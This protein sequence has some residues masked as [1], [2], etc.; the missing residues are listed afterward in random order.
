MPTV[1][2]LLRTGRKED[3]WQKCCG[4]LD[5][6]IEQF[7][8]IQRRLLLEQI[9]LLNASA[10]GKKIFKGTMP[11]DVEEFR[12]RAPLT[13]YQDYCPELSQKLDA[14]MPLKPLLWQHTSGRSAEYPFKWESIKWVPVTQRMCEEIAAIGAGLA[15]LASCKNK[16]DVSSMNRGAKFIYAVA[17]RPYTSGTY[18]YIAT[19]EVEG[20]SMPPLEIAEKL[21]IEERIA[22]SFK[23][24]LS[25]GLDFYFGVSVALVAIG[26]K[27]NQRM[28]KVNIKS[29]LSQPRALARLARGLIKSKLAGRKLMP[30]D[31]WTIK[32]ILSSGTDATI[33]KNVIKDTW[34]V[35]PLD[36][37]VSTEGSM[38]ATQTWDYDGMTFIPNMNFFEFIPEAEYEKWKENRS[39]IPR[40]V[41]LDEVQ[42]NSK[43]ELVISNFHGAPL[44]RYRTGDIIKITSLRNKKLNIELPQMEFEGRIDDAID[45][46]GFFGL[47]EKVIW[48]AVSNTA[49]PYVDWA[50]R[51]ERKEDKSSLHVYL[52]LKGDI[53]LEEDIIAR[54]IY[55]ELKK[56]DEGF[57]YAD[58]RTVLNTVPVIVT[59]LPKG[60]FEN[61]INLRRSQGADL[62]HLK[63]RHMNLSDKELAILGR[64]VAAS[65]EAER[66]SVGA[67][68]AS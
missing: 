29:L 28:G 40:T 53:K 61:H 37:Y 23:Q 47:T 43:Y 16:G 12:K 13:T 30:K 63:P 64:P 50:A 1:K 54:A 67:P 34:G 24:A 66:V 39:Y 45:A 57:I 27:I 7:M 46:G 19:E 4:F 48:Q 58:V 22:L 14:A 38:I 31:L 11:Q 3:L 25:Q 2:E 26:E 17:P 55:A 6:S 10:I 8:S 68:A 62:A 60:A 36:V 35:Y 52:E 32:G 20:I 33:F 49:I 56:M 65:P 44:I 59:L 15:I 41:M 9:E 5:L 21:D 42:P 18:A 51:E